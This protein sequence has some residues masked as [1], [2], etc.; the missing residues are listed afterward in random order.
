M[1]GHSHGAH[2]TDMRFDW[3]WAIGLAGIAGTATHVLVQMLQQQV[4]QGIA[5][6]SI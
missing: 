2:S 6:I 5:W 3:T 4:R 1:H